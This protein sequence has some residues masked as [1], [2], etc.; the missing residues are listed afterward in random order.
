MAKSK[1]CVAVCYYED[2]PDFLERL[3]VFD[4]PCA[5]SPLHSPCDDKK[6]HWHILSER[7]VLEKLGSIFGLRVF[8]CLEP[9]AYFE[10]LTHKNDPDKEQF[11]CEPFLFG[12]FV[13]PV[14]K[15]KPKKMSKAEVLSHTLDLIED[16]QFISYRRFLKYICENESSEYINGVMSNTYTLLQLFIR[17]V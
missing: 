15:S 7:S 1:Y 4:F 12:D 10:Y 14:S 2:Y 5:V 3:K 16:Y 9:F 6:P 17:E 13:P 11:D 8:S